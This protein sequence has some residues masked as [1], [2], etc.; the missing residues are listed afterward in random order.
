[1]PFSNS[2]VACDISSTPVSPIVA[3]PVIDFGLMN[4]LPKAAPATIRENEMGYTPTSKMA[5]PARSVLNK[6]D[7]GTVLPISKPNDDLMFFT[8]PIFF[9]FMKF[10]KAGI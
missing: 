3:V 5:P 2:R 4:F 7:S 10:A 6:R 9:S 8:S 1:M